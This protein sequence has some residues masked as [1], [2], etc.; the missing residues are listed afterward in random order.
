MLDYTFYTYFFSTIKVITKVIQVRN[1]AMHSPDLKMNNEDMISH[2]NTVL[3]LAKTLEPL[4]P[5]LKGLEKEITQVD[6][7]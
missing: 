6:G 5:K 7:Q 2:R 1:N 3:Q 4:I